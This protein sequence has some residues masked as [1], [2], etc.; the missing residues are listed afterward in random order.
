M[1]IFVYS[2]VGIRSTHARRTRREIA[3][4]ASGIPRL[5]SLKSAECVRRD[6]ASRDETP[7]VPVCRGNEPAQFNGTNAQLDAGRFALSQAYVESLDSLIAPPCRFESHSL[8]G[9]LIGRR[10]PQLAWSVQVYS[11]TLPHMVYQQ[12][13]NY[14]MLS[15]SVLAYLTRAAGSGIY[16][17]DYFALKSATRV[18]TRI[19]GT[20]STGHSCALYPS[21]TPNGWNDGSASDKQPWPSDRHPEFQNAIDTSRNHLY[22][23]SSL[24]CN[25]TEDDT[26]RMEL[27]A[28]P[29]ENTWTPLSP[30]TTPNTV[31]SSAMCYHAAHDVLVLHG[32][33]GGGVGFPQTWFFAP[34]PEGN[35][36]SALQIAAGCST[37]EDWIR[38]YNQ[39]ESMIPSLTLHNNLHDDPRTGKILMF[40]VYDESGPFTTEVWA[41]DP[42]LHTWTNLNPANAPSNLQSGTANSEFLVTRITSGRW[43]G[44]FHFHRTSHASEGDTSQIADYLY[45]SVANRFYPLNTTGTGPDAGTF[46]VFDPTIGAHGGI[47][48]LTGTVGQ[49]PTFWHG[50]LQ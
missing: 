49:T 24:A 15:A 38:V 36:L 2:L 6:L 46:E 29:T 32:R 25:S 7:G 13:P 48:A 23:F 17:T 8:M 12:R 16:S 42:V 41:F 14:D 35:G 30:A 47:V 27:N 45:D 22:Q 28:D 40:G 18:S 44:F 4:A 11:G 37:P 5:G 31:H 3:A 1:R 19:G 20:G 33:S 21:S 26:L 9:I 10:L 39:T 43:S 50:E 34:D